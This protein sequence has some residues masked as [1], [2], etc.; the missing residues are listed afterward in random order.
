[1]IAS[2][3]ALSPSSHATQ[4]SFHILTLFAI[5]LFLCPSHCHARTPQAAPVSQAVP[6]PAPA[7]DGSHDFDFNIGTWHTHIRRV[8]DP[9]T[10][11][12]KTVEL[13]GTVTVRKVW[14]GKAQLEEIEAEGPK[15][16]WEGATLFLYN[17]DTHEWSQTFADSQEGVFGAPLLGAFRDGRGELYSQDTIHGRNILVR[18]TWSEIKPDSH[19]FEE[20]LSN[21]AGQTWRPAFIA[22]LTRETPATAVAIPA[23][24]DLPNSNDPAHAL[25]W[26]LGS[27]KIHM[28]RLVHPLTGSSTWTQM[29]GT[30][31]N[32]RVWNGRANLAEVEADGPTGHLELLALRLYNPTTHEWNVNF[33][34]SGVGVLNT[35]TGQ[36]IIGEFKDGR[37]EFIDQ[38]PFNGRTILVRFRIWPIDANHAQS[39]QAFSADGGKTWETNWINHY[40]RIQSN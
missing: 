9:Y 10:D 38:E 30:T 22:D 3:A 20:D 32:S 16:H 15:G 25:D 6:A 36:P 34:T 12:S 21:D 33:A 39:E 37:G 28:D 19:H 40:T 26:D 17:P 31:V 35:P 1:M 14:N 23:F 18:G 2:R 24:S 7:R 27:W 29:D 11:P 5:A 13:N 4:H 8:P